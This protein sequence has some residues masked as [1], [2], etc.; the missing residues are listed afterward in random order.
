M[1][2]IRYFCNTIIFQS[3]RPARGATK[4]AARCIVLIDIS[5]HAPR[6]GRDRKNRKAADRTS[7]FN[8][9][10]PRGARQPTCFAICPHL[11][12]QSTR[13]ARGATELLGRAV[14]LEY[15]SIH[16]PRE[17]RDCKNSGY[18]PCSYISIH[19]PR[20]GRDCP[21]RG[22]EQVRRYFNPRAPRG[23]RLE[24]LMSIVDGIIISIHAPRE[25]RDC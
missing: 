24:M 13:P 9:R 6:E 11:S 14:L 22:R 7:Y 23:A 5:I 21:H 8:P 1:D 17:G 16:A 10:A 12:F 19:A 3:T 2:D 4:A 25:G 18:H 15:I 20:E